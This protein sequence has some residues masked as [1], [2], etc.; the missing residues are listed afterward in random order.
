[1][2]HFE[3][4]IPSAGEDNERNFKTN[5]VDLARKKGKKKETE[6]QRKDM[7]KDLLSSCDRKLTKQCRVLA[8]Q[9]WHL[10]AQ[11][12]WRIIAKNGLT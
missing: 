4:A 8:L 11:N 7:I 3:L 6:R 9:K 1:M 12:N 10:H 2:Q 5:L